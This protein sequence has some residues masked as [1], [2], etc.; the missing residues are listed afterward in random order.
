M[1]ES[2]NI[3]IIALFEEN[4]K[5][6]YD[7]TIYTT[8]CSIYVRKGAFIMIKGVGLDLCQIERMNRLLTD[9]R[10]LNRYFVQ[11]EISY[12]HSKGKNAAQTLAGIYAAKEALTKALGTGISFDL[13]EIVI[14]HNESGAPRYLLSG[15]AAK[16]SEGDH[17]L[18][19]I[20]HDGGIAA[21]VCVREADC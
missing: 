12:I 8:G 3:F 16:L 15:T 18:L 10:F 6:W 4:R 19:S 5:L 20:S 9:E 14:S 21:A 1:K 7:L 17:Y 2:H 13:K 11:E